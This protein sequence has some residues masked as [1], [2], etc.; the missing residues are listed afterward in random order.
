MALFWPHPRPTE[1]ETPRWDAANC[2]LISPSL[3]PLWLLLQKD[4]KRATYKQHHL[5]LT[6]VKAGKSK[7]TGRFRVWW[8]SASHKTSQAEGAKEVCGISFVR[9]WV[10]FMRTLSVWPNHLP[11]TPPPNSITLEARILKCECGGGHFNLLQPLQGL[12]MH[13]KIWKPLP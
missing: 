13:A 8:G 3:S 9:V 10:P 7:V 2:V 1:P 5:F 12:L 4:H 11:K 6:V